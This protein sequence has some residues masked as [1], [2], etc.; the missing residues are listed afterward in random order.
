[1]IDKPSLSQNHTKNYK[2]P[3]TKQEKMKIACRVRNRP[4]GNRNTSEGGANATTGTFLTTF[5]L[6][7][8][9]D[10]VIVQFLAK[11]AQHTK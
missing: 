3:R 7:T 5:F 9:F 4:V 2:R 10:R 11:V 6:T 1:M 8:L